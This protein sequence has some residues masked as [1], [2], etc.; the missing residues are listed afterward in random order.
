[1]LH[2]VCFFEWL[3]LQLLELLRYVPAAIVKL[4]NYKTDRKMEIELQLDLTDE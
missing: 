1:M 2:S 4:G 3:Q